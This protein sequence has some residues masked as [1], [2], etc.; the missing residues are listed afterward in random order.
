MPTVTGDNLSLFLFVPSVKK[1]HIIHAHSR[2]AHFY[3]I[4]DRTHTIRKFAI[5]WRRRICKNNILIKNATKWW[6]RR[7]PIWFPACWL[8]I[9]IL[10]RR[11]RSSSFPFGRFLAGSCPV[12]TCQTPLWSSSSRPSGPWWRSALQRKIK[13]IDI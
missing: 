12:V 4:V 9:V 6:T 1:L 2:H 13:T 11:S 7:S 8:G 3:L 5:S 10:L